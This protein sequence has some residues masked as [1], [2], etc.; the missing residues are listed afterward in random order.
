MLAEGSF[1]R[2]STQLTFDQSLYTDKVT[3]TNELMPRSLK[4]TAE[5]QSGTGS[6]VDIELHCLDLPLKWRETV[7]FA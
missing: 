7:P 3:I 4:T 1:G 5:F 6:T 2:N